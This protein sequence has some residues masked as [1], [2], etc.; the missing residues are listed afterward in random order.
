MKVQLPTAKGNISSVDTNP[1]V[2]AIIKKEIC[3][4]FDR[5]SSKKYAKIFSS[6]LWDTWQKQKQQWAS[7]GGDFTVTERYK[8]RN[9]RYL[10]R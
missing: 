2:E 3:I 9:S 7:S 4:I 6:K 5:V 8:P 1:V 10:K